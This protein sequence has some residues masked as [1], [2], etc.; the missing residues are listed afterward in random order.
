MTHHQHRVHRGKYHTAYSY[1]ATSPSQLTQ[2]KGRRAQI[3]KTQTRPPASGETER[4][5]EVMHAGALETERVNE[6]DG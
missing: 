6:S 3:S 5:Q 1:K 4:A 2:M